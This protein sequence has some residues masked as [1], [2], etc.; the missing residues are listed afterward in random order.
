MATSAAVLAGCGSM[1]Q[2]AA[3]TLAASDAVAIAPIANFTETPAAGGSAAALAA[4]ILR[5]NGLADVRLA[6]VDGDGNAMFDT[7]QRDTGERRLAWAR[8]HHV[9]Y[10]LAG[11][12][13]EWRYKAGVDGEP[14]AGLTFELVDVESGRV[15]W[16]AAGTRSGWS[17]S[18]LSSV[19][20]ALVGRLLAPLRP[21]S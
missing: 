10:V 15:V 18:S 11:A 5:A 2:T 7:A 9:K 6:P 1:R 17:R 21:R 19:A 8:E 3:P 12:V 14:V 16:S 20:N 13:E 4:T